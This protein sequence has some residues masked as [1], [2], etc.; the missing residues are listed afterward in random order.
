ML[1]ICL[2]IYFTAKFCIRRLFMLGAGQYPFSVSNL[3]SECSLPWNLTDGVTQNSP[4]FFH[5]LCN[6]CIGIK[7]GQRQEE[8]QK[9]N[10]HTI[11]CPFCNE[12]S[13]FKLNMA[14]SSVNYHA[15]FLVEYV[16]FAIAHG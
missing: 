1:R 3:C 9:F 13:A 2:F 8:E 7:V 5:V 16:T 12:S 10:I 6:T 11:P 14:H 4:T 15:I